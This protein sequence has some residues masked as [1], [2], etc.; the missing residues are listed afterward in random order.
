M[1][2]V[3]EVYVLSDT[4]GSALLNY[5]INFLFKTVWYLCL[6]PLPRRR[7]VSYTMMGNCSVYHLP[8]GQLYKRQCGNQHYEGYLQK[9]ETNGAYLALNISAQRL[10]TN[11][12]MRFSIADLDPA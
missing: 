2:G 11:L 1:N 5:Y 3:P 7:I 10:A 12:S 8:F 9:F 4:G 6:A